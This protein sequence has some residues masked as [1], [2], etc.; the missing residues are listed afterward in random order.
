MRKLV[1]LFSSFL[2]FSCGNSETLTIS[3]EEY[4]KL[5]GVKQSEYPKYFKLNDSGLSITNSDGIVLGS[6]GHEYL[7]ISWGRNT[8]DVEHYVDCKFCAKRDKQ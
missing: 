5:K 8:M 2:V 6:D 1:F 4:N 7:V 3:K